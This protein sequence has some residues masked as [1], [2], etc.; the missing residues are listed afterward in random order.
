M[1]WCEGCEEELPSIKFPHKDSEFCIDC[2]IGRAESQY[3][4]SKEGF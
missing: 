1:M 4:A 2:T 3:D